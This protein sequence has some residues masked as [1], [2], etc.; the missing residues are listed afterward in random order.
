M[1]LF[2]TLSALTCEVWL[3]LLCH[4]LRL[5]NSGIN[6]AMVDV[7]LLCAGRLHRVFG[8][9]W[10]L[11]EAVHRRGSSIQTQRQSHP[12]SALRLWGC[13]HCSGPQW[14]AGKTVSVSPSSSSSITWVS[15]FLAHKKREEQGARFCLKLGLH[16]LAA[17]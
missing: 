14:R 1:T 7:S 16:L 3:I 2:S 11:E 4:C 17:S 15:S 13:H 10:R 8:D 6:A 5:L 9:S 12:V